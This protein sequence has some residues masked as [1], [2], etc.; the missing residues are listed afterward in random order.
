MRKL[1]ANY[2]FDGYKFHKNAILYVSDNGKILDLLLTE[3]ELSEESRLEFYNGILCPG[4][5]NAHC[6]LELSGLKGKIK[7][8]SKLPEFISQIMSVNNKFDERAMELADAEMQRNGIVAVGDISNTD[9]SFKLKAGSRIKYHTFIE[10]SGPD[11]NKADKV[12]D[13]AL[14]LKKQADINNLRNNIVPHAPYSVSDKLLEIVKDDAY[15]TNSIISI[16]NQET[17]TEN[18]MFKNGSGDLLEALKLINPFY[19]NFKPT[20]FN[21]LASTLV[22]LPKCNKVML[23]HNTY[24]SSKDI[25]WTN[26]YTKYSYWC[27]CP[28]SNLF[29]EDKLPDLNLF[30]NQKVCIGTDSY[31]SNT[32]LS[33]LD[34]IKTIQNYFEEI[35]LSDLLK[36]ATYNGA[37]ALDLHFEFGSFEKGKTPGVVLL[38][39]VDLQNMKLKDESKVR[40]LI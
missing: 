34:E 5:V 11:R 35:P 6:H 3:G 39:D 19:E 2:I 18:E 28:N 25:K 13:R 4:F 31:A 1:S 14:E 36:W 9:F 12:L 17:E 21:S 32:G 38:E 7:P 22:H 10:V 33:V 15:K 27:I 29:I 30:M 8:K 37:E 20:Y 24:T 40:V 16:H 23:V 26:D